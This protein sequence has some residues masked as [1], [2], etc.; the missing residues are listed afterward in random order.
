MCTV[1]TLYITPLH[2]KLAMTQVSVVCAGGIPWWN[3][4]LGGLTS[5]E[6]SAQ[7]VHLATQHGLI[8]D[9]VTGQLI[10]TVVNV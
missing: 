2:T 7:Q 5:D 3:Y 4:G 10:R 6:A 9:L 1:Y 8:F